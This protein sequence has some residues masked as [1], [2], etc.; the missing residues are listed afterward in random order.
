MSKNIFLENCIDLVISPSQMFFI[1][2][3]RKKLYLINLLNLNFEVWTDFSGNINSVVV[4]ENGKYILVTT[5]Y[6]ECPLYVIYHSSLNFF[7]KSNYCVNDYDID[8]KYMH[9]DY[10]FFHKI[11]NLTFS[12]GFLIEKIEINI[13]QNRLL[14]LYRNKDDDNFITK[15][16][17]F[18]IDFNKDINNFSIEFLLPFNELN[19]MNITHFQSTFN[20]QRE[21]ETFFIVIFSL[22][23]SGI[24]INS[25]ISL[26]IQLRAISP[27]ILINK[28]RDSLKTTLKL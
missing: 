26:F 19:K 14:V 20:L 24:T 27:L 21:I 3:S 8:Q 23:R 5:D 11:Y 10:H 16:M 25:E 22:F 12:K 6:N 7:N 15:V 4:N 2:F 18:Q 9:L 13:E 17:L 1:L 28:Y